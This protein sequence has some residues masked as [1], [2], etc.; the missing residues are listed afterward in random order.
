MARPRKTKIEKPKAKK[1][2]RPKNEHLEMIEAPKIEPII[3]PGS[4]KNSLPII[5]KRIGE[6][7]FALENAMALEDKDQIKQYIYKIKTLTHLQED[8]LKIILEDYNSIP[9]NHYYR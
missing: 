6:A 2:G 9:D 5:H 8:I 7:I 4:L 1:R 3:L